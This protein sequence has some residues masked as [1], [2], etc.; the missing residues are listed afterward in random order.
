[1]SGLSSLRYVAPAA[2]ARATVEPLVLDEE[3]PPEATD[4]ASALEL[5]NWLRAA[6]IEEEA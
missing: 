4:L 6:L 1:M 3:V 2:V 5:L